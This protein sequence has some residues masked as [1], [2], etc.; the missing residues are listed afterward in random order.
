MR[1]CAYKVVI[2]KP[3][4][5]DYLPLESAD[6]IYI[7]SCTSINNTHPSYKISSKSLEQF[8]RGCAIK[9]LMSSMCLIS[10][11]HMATYLMILVYFDMMSFLI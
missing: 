1:S 4:N 8:R 3:L 11:L 9:V 6:S 2:C 7:S 5:L 10:N